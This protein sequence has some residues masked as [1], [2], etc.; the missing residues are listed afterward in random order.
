VYSKNLKILL[1]K[2]PNRLDLRRLAWNI[3]LWMSTMFVQI[4]ALG[5]ELAL[6]HG[7]YIQVS[8]LRPSCFYITA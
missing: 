7:A 2:K 4:K 6:L 8:N 1:L 5:F 3:F